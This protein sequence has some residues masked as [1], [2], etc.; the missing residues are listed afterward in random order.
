MTMTKNEINERTTTFP[1]GDLFLKS[2]D[3][4]MHFWKLHNKNDVYVRYM[5]YSHT[6]AAPVWII[7]SA[8]DKSEFITVVKDYLTVKNQEV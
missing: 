1:K 2:T 8:K 5:R 4:S 7:G 6:G 3:R